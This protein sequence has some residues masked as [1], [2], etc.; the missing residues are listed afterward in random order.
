MSNDPEKTK[1]VSEWPVPKNV[2][3][4]R[5]FWG[6]CSYY[7]KF[8]FYFANIARPIHKLTEK[9]QSFVWT[10]ECQMAFENLKQALTNTPILAYPRNEDSFFLE[11]DAS[12][13]S[14]GA[15]LSQIQDGK[16]KVIAYYSKAF[17]RTERKYCVTRRE[18]LAAVA[19]I[20]HFHHYLY[21]RHFLVRSDHGALRWLLNFKN[22]EGQIGRWFENLAAYDFEIEYRAGCS[23]ANADAMS[24]RPC[25]KKNCSHM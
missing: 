12:N 22:P 17:S 1:A 15:V 24:R 4:V 18:L 25:H 3:E 13:T 2:K 14:M 7:R 10:E 19:S 21:G 6:L 8:I 11:T 5:S 16:E 23:H 9:N 20:K